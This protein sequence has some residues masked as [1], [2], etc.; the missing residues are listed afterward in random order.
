MKKLVISAICAVILLA[1]TVPAQAMVARLA[2]ALLGAAENKAQANQKL[3]MNLGFALNAQSPKT[4]TR[5]YLS[6]VSIVKHNWLKSLYQ[7]KMCK[8]IIV[9]MDQKEQQLS[10]THYVFYHGQDKK[11]LI[12]H[13]LATLLAASHDKAYIS[14]DFLLLQF[15]PDALATVNAQ[16]F[17]DAKEVSDGKK[18]DTWVDNHDFSLKNNLMSTNIS[19]FG[20]S[21]IPW[22]SSLTYF[23]NSVSVDMS[24]YKKAI[25]KL[26]Q[27]YNMTDT[28]IKRIHELAQIANDN[29]FGNLFQIFVPK[30]AVDKYAYLAYPYG[31]PWSTP[32]APCCFDTVK[33]RHTKISPILE[34]YKN[35]P[36]SFD[37]RTMDGM[38]ARLFVTQD[39]LL[40]PRSGVKI[41]RYTTIDQA[42]MADYKKKLQVLVQE[43]A[44]DAP[45]AMHDQAAAQLDVNRITI[46]L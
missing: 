17:I 45:A 35:N 33:G 37:I 10:D 40:N 9:Q 21:L 42:K 14:D 30:D 31:T 46:T 13:D 25:N 29:Q 24:A 22:E 5:S 27:H 7:H 18:A 6:H 43:L 2:H 15:K 23:I 26:C 8:H 20:N 11:F 34:R 28:H 4:I 12:I 16:E 19:M 41:Y 38:Q 39:M 1:Q 3:L 36:Q 44:A 32:L